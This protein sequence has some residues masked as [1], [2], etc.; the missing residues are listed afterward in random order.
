M[1]LAGL[2]K[3]AN[4]VEKVYS[5][6]DK[7]NA[8]FI[9]KG[10]LRCPPGCGI[11]CQGQHI[12]ASELEFL[13]LALHYYDQGII[14]EKYWLYRD[15][16]SGA[17]LLYNYDEPALSRCGV[18]PYRALVCRLF[19]NSALSDQNGQKRYLGCTI[20]KDQASQVKN[21]D[22]SLIRYA[23]VTLDFY[24]RLSTLHPQYGSELKPINQALIGALEIVAKHT[25]ELHTVQYKK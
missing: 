4:Q 12:A 22:A 8:K 7:L 23:P 25:P 16:P 6:L 9:E 20:L 24:L 14:E 1:P 3:L 13:P 17:C 15:K 18:Y 19:G 11:C 10:N 5:R 21:F 2:R